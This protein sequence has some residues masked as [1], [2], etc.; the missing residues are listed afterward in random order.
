MSMMRERAE[1][2][3][4]RTVLLLLVLAVLVTY[5]AGILAGGFHFDDLHHVRDNPSVRTL[6]NPLPF[7]GDA[8]LWSGEPGNQ[9]YRP[10]G[11]VV[12]ALDFAAWK[13]LAGNGLHGPGW[14]LTNA[15]LHAFVSFLVFLLGTR[16]GL[17]RL[18]AFLAA[19]VMAM[20]PLHSEVV[21]YVSAR[22]EST[23]AV[24]VILALL[25]HWKARTAVGRRRWAFTALAVLLS[26]M[27]MTCKE[28]AA[29]FF[30]AV[31]WME[32][33]LADGGV[34]AR[35]RTAA[36]RGAVYV[37]PLVVY[38]LLRREMI[39]FA[40]APIVMHGA[41]GIDP[42]IG[43]HRTFSANLATQARAGVLYLQLWLRPLR[44][45]AD[46]DVG[47]VST[48]VPAVAAAALLHVTLVAGALRE[49]LRG[50]RLLPLA[51]GWAY[52]FVLPSTLI[53]LNVVMNEHRMY[54]P[55]IAVALLAGAA[56]A[57]VFQVLATER[58]RGLAIAAT[59]LPLCLFAVLAADRSLEWRDDATLWSSAA[60]RS[61]LSARAHMHVGAAYHLNA[62]SV[63]GEDA[64]S[65]L[66]RALTSYA[67]ADELHPGWYDLQ[68]NLGGAWLARGRQ[69]QDDA[70][71]QRALDA[72]VAAGRI[73]GE[74]KE[75]PRFLQSAA[76]TELRRYDDAVRILTEMDEADD[77]V[78]TIY[79]DAIARALRKKGDRAG[80]ARHMARVIEIEEPI[81]RAEGLLT[82]G[83]WY[84]EDGDLSRS[85]QMLSRALAIGKR[86][87]QFKPFLY[88]ARFLN[89]VGQ[90]GAG[91]FVDSA[92]KLGW[93]AL[94]R[95]VT[96]VEGGPTP[97]A[98]TTLR[99]P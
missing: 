78:T 56:L 88:I 67:R 89:V 92:K 29:T 68:L 13:T 79:D 11:M 34:G 27:A 85:E 19:L 15:L 82:L 24:F 52:I 74:N 17:S 1:V 42:Q 95:E 94:P 57:R 60:K 83:W 69:S 26:F 53:P 3:R 7:Y 87:G 86:K 66:D 55:G 84:F 62:Q 47:A 70:D 50:K 33:V 18:A 16:L 43:G 2:L 28:T 98:R 71:F 63:S 22:S 77:D 44:L 41:G 59:A 58:S 96:W 37:L 8:S 90:P 81:D 97:G 23:A 73:V 54:L 64:V 20:H 5:A 39:G 10:T 65:E 93:R 31:V 30:A 32:L 51:V 36:L 75:R 72:Y 48:S 61:P 21:N 40:T 46:H 76:L 49:L 35:I 6:G 99:K 4:P 38:L 80:A 12:H 9:M 14:V 91:E 45:A 25:A